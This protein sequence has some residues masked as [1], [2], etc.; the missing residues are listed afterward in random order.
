MWKGAATL[1][2]HL[3]A[4]CGLVSIFL[5]GNG[6]KAILRKGKGYKGVRRGACPERQ[7]ILRCPF[8]FYLYL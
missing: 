1:L 6:D 2:L 5:L 8:S 3:L 7:E 4:I